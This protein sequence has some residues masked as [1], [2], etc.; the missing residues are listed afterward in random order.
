MKDFVKSLAFAIV[1]VFIF[2]ACNSKH[3]ADT[4]KYAIEEYA[5]TEQEDYLMAIH[6]EDVQFSPQNSTTGSNIEQKLI[7][8]AWVEFETSNME[9]AKTTIYQ[10]VKKHKG[11]VSS[12]AENQNSYRISN[13]IIIRI[14]SENF[15]SFLHDAT[16]EVKQFDK[17]EINIHDVTEEF[18]DVEARLKAKKELENRYLELLQKAKNVSEML[19][20]EREIGKLRADIEAMDG[21]MKYL[22]NQVSFSTLTFTFYKKNPEKSEL[23]QKIKISLQDG[24]GYL[25]DF[26]AFLLSILPFILLVLIIVFIFR[27]YRKRRK[28]KREKNQKTL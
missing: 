22:Q 26:F 5:A 11:Y 27:I 2:V 24:W 17:K 10:A 7:K 3:P 4:K 9:N 12:D 28:I 19:E 13:T 14:P 6:I 8:E 23:E 25:I 15:D 1:F 16:A 21:R 20:I 18:L